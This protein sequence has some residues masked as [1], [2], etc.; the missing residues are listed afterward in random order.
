MSTFFKTSRRSIRKNPQKAYFWRPG[1]HDVLWR[2]ATRRVGPEHAAQ[3]LVR[4]GQRI[5]VPSKELG[6]GGER[7]FAAYLRRISA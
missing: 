2:R 3:Q 5:P 7:G 1:P 6:S 4:S